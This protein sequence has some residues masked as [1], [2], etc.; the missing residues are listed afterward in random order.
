MCL[1]GGGSQNAGSGNYSMAAGAPPMSGP[2]A[3]DSMNA[4]V[5]PLAN[6]PGANSV[7]P[8]L[9][10][11]SGL[12]DTKKGQSVLPALLGGVASAPGGIPVP[13]NTTMPAVGKIGGYQPNALAQFLQRSQAGANPQSLGLLSGL[14][15]G[16]APGSNGPPS[17]G[18]TVPTPNPIGRPPDG[19]GIP[20]QIPGGTTL[21][22]PVNNPGGSTPDPSA[23]LPTTNPIKLPGGDAVDTSAPAPSSGV[24]MRPDASAPAGPAS[25]S[26]DPGMRGF[27]QS[28]M[29][30]V[31][32]SPKWL[33][34]D[35]IN[36]MYTNPNFPQ[37][38]MQLSGKKPGDPG[39]GNG[40]GGFGY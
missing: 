26:N 30:P 38:I 37:L 21:P 15:T 22:Q 3:F 2:G 34:Q 1:G 24:F 31:G 12:M 9:K 6:G 18:G 27:V 39:V 40:Y 5:S 14:L 8:L 7:L 16:A 19:T 10:M 13:G 28:Q 23:T 35:V 25:W 17:P 11:L 4:S 33:T 36:Q 32:G 29:Y 20:G